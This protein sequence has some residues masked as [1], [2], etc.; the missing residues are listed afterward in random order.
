MER[1]DQAF[2]KDGKYLLN[3]KV[4]DESDMIETAQFLDEKEGSEMWTILPKD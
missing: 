3:G 2:F 1:G 4:I